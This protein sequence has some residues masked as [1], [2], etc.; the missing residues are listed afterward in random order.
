[1]K[2]VLPGIGSGDSVIL[3]AGGMWNWVDPSTL[4]RAVAKLRKDRPDVHAVILG[5]KHPNPEIGEMDIA[6]EA[7]A[8]AD[9]LG[10]VGNGVNFVEWV[11]YEERAEWILEADVGVSLHHSGVESQFAYR[12][13]LLDYICRRDSPG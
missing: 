13:R 4:I 2:G 3:W 10:L 5:T 8:L 12:T 7:Q 1:M 11:P 6:R 9:D